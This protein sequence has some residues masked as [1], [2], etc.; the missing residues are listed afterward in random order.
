MIEKQHRMIIEQ[1]K[2]FCESLIKN[3]EI[4]RDIYSTVSAYTKE[5]IDLSDTHNKRMSK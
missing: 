1:Q 5:F 4:W 2:K 3:K